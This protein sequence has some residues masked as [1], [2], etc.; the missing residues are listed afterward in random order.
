MQGIGAAGRSFW[1]SPWLKRG[2]CADGDDD[3]DDDDWFAERFL[4]P[5]LLSGYTNTKINCANERNR[6]VIHR[7]AETRAVNQK[8]P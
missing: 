2:C 8:I 6:L 3:D 5:E 4:L 7:L 1:R